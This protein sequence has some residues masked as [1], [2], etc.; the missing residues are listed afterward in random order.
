L[1]SA[2][3]IEQGLCKDAIE[4]FQIFNGRELAEDEVV[5]VLKSLD[6]CG[7]GPDKDQYNLASGVDIEKPPSDLPDLHIPASLPPVDFS[8]DNKHPELQMRAAERQRDRMLG[9][10]KKPPTGRITISQFLDQGGKIL[11][12]QIGVDIGENERQKSRS[13][14]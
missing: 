13:N 11:P 9:R 10:E 4:I 8:M 12:G 2:D 14:R 1:I 6:H 3:I 7:S 5:V